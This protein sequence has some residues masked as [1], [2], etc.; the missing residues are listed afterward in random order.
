MINISW[1]PVSSM[2]ADHRLGQGNRYDSEII[3]TKS[4]FFNI[5]S[6]E[7]IVLLTFGRTP[8]AYFAISLPAAPA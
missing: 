3:S 2:I 7:D 5:L 1:N 6:P 4:Y 8:Y